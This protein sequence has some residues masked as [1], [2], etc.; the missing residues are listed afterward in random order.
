MRSI[1]L[2][3]NLK[4]LI[5]TCINEENNCCFSPDYVVKNCQLNDAVL[6]L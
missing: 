3:L 1:S 2:F 4:K 6:V 5:K